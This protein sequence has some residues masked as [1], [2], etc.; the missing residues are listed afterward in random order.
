[1]ITTKSVSTG[2]K[3]QKIEKT[4]L[5]LE[6]LQRM[7]KSP[8]AKV[9]TV[10]F[11]LIVLA[12]VCAPL[13]APYGPNDMDL[14]NMYASPSCVPLAGYRRAGARPAEPPA[15][16]R[17]LL[18]VFGPFRLPVWSICRCCPRQY[19]RLF[20]G[21]DGDPDHA[22]DGHLVLT[23]RDAAVHP[24]LGYPGCRLF[25]YRPGSVQL[26]KCRLVSV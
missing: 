6:T 11:V 19:C 2:S 4:S 21:Q 9:G 1:M 20:R 15:V 23:S 24:D 18:P 3:P 12:C 25:Q 17:S 13:I 26:A 22:P 8:G 16:W 5:F 7:V 10:L 14:K